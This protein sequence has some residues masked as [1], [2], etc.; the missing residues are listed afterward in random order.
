M[1]TIFIVLLGVVYCDFCNTQNEM[2]ELDEKSRSF[3]LAMQSREKADKVLRLFD[4]IHAPKLLYSIEDKHYLVIMK[5]DQSFSEYYVK[6]TSNSNISDVRLLNS[7]EEK[8]VI[9]IRAF[10]FEKYSSELIFDNRGI[11]SVK[12]YF[13]VKDENGNRYGECSVLSLPFVHIDDELD[14]YCIKRLA[15]IVYSFDLNWE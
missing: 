12:K 13:V 4:T 1:K 8:S 3:S 5:I 14:M 10:D 11:I 7:N 9:L 2:N 15:E 6:M